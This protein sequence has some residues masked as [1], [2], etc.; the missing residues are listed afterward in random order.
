MRLV[1]LGRLDAIPCGTPALAACFESLPVGGPKRRDVSFPP[2]AVI[3]LGWYYA[4]C[5]RLREGRPRKMT[6]TRQNFDVGIMLRLSYKTASVLARKYRLIFALQLECPF[7]GYE[8]TGVS[9]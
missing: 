9:R 1:L 3:K 4:E 6:T 7:F 5:R 8:L 2:K